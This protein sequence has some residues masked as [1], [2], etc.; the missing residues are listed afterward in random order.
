MNDEE[1]VSY[2]EKFVEQLQ[3]IDFDYLV[4]NGK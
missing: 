2:L 4:E 3:L 1:V